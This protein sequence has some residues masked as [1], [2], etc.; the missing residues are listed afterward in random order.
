MAQKG[1][2]IENSILDTGIKDIDNFRK[3]G[4]YFAED[5]DRYFKKVSTSQLRKFFGALKRIQA[6]FDQM[7]GEIILL[8]AQLA[9]AVG[10][11]V[12]N[13]KQSTKIK[14]FYDLIGPLL[15]A[16]KEDKKMF[17]NFVNV[18]E[19]IVA[20]HKEKEDVKLY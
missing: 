11:D 10:R 16:I 3:W 14:E 13:G 1:D 9:Y 6:D 2:V 8:D 7:K 20:Y 5:Q 12:S 17:K 15:R 18:F 19:A 4:H